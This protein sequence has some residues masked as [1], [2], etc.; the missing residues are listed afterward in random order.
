M[1]GLLS[2]RVGLMSA[3]V[4]MMLILAACGGNNNAA[5]P[6]TSDSAKPTASSTASASNQPAER[7][8]LKVLGHASWFKSGWDAVAK[9]AAAHGF[10]LE[11]EKVPDTDAGNDL[12]KTRFATKD[13]PDILLFF[14]GSIFSN[15]G[16]PADYFVKQED[17][18][19]MD[20]FDKSAWVRALDEKEN[21]N[22]DR[23]FYAAPYWGSNVSAVLYNKKVFESLNLQIPKTYADFL[24][25]CE[26]IKKAGKI[27]VY[28]SGKD[29]WTL[30]LLP[31]DAASKKGY[32]ELADK[33]NKNQAKFTQYDNM[34]KGIETL[35]D[36]KNK[37]FINKTF[38]SDTYDN[39]EKA[40]ATGEA[41]MYHMGTWMMSDIVT[42]FQ[43][44]VN[45]I[46]A[47][48]MPFDGDDTDILPVFAPYGMFVPKGKNQDAAQKFV[49][50]FESI[51]TQNLYFEN[52]GGIPA[53]NG[54]TKTKLTPAELDAKT[55]VDAGRKFANWQY[56]FDYDLSN[57]GVYL[58]D[59]LVGNK[60]PDQVLAAMD[61]DFAKDA[62]T[63][64]DP[65]F[66]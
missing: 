41:G 21:V 22:G 15:M 5:S 58:Q 57:F 39:A 40:L 26:A 59:A 33:I 27:P 37:G 9:D 36:L 25:V 55:L 54:V 62:K 61:K 43:D 52:E 50:Y 10:D 18:P 1:R 28:Y 38:L 19:W 45:D 63:K 48:I 2:K 3:I 49:N 30:Q 20:N 65:N 14:P 56:G 53:L 32:G 29:S 24:A 60:T 47:F 66:Q 11:V 13:T 23:G 7:V 31:F 6:S 35:V 46:G 42:K 4:A 16:P 64:K 12:I 34:K 51:E 44:N 8:K 17:Q